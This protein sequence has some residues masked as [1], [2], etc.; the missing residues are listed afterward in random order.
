M[1]IL[2]LEDEE[3]SRKMLDVFLKEA[4]H[5]TVALDSVL[6]AFEHIRKGAID[7][8]LMDIGLPGLNGIS[9]TQK[10]KKYPDLR[11]IP[12][13]VITGQ[14]KEFLEGHALRSGCNAYLEKPVD[15]TELLRL[16]AQF[17]T[18]RVKG[19]TRSTTDKTE[20]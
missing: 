15:T 12:I 13:I 20:D 16:I 14:P 19:D 8:I 4:G 5:K 6:Q 18:P 2:I 10:I 1:N 17:S 3:G 9:F 7:L 11:N